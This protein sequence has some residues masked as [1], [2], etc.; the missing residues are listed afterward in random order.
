MTHCQVS[1]MLLHQLHDLFIHRFKISIFKV[2][3][4]EMK[5]FIERHPSA[6]GL[7][8]DVVHLVS[9]KAPAD[10]VD[11]GSGAE[12]RPQEYN[13]DKQDNCVASTAHSG[14]TTFHRSR[15]RRPFLRKV[16]NV[17]ASSY[18]SVDARLSRSKPENANYVPRHKG[19]PKGSLN[20]AQGQKPSMHPKQ[21]KCT[22]GCPIHT[23]KCRMFRNK[24]TPLVKVANECRSGQ[25][26]ANAQQASSRQPP[27]ASAF[28]YVHSPPKSRR[29]SP[30][31]HTGLSEWAHSKIKL[32]LEQLRNAP[33]SEQRAILKRKMLI[34]H[35]DKLH[36]TSASCDA[37]QCSELFQEIQRMYQSMQPAWA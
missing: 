37:Q 24:F 35:P 32:I 8:G 6:F 33:D 36:D 28:Q 21:V 31:I 26:Y 3:G 12:G 5:D 2:T 10:A 17:V 19:R 16:Q 22:C 11:S 9:G 29:I 4:F 25:S 23:E 1:S 18:S 15:D 30:A 13:A 34:Y 14:K 7:Q 20:R 27:P